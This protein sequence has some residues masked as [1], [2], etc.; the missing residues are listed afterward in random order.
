M[1]A[2]GSWGRQSSDTAG[3]RAGQQGRGGLGS[4]GTPTASSPLEPAR[5]CPLPAPALQLPARQLPASAGWWEEPS[6]SWVSPARP[7]RRGEL[8][9]GNSRLPKPCP[10]RESEASSQQ[11]RWRP[12]SGPLP[13]SAPGGGHCGLSCV[14]PTPNLYGDTLS[15]GP[16]TRLSLEPGPHSGHEGEQVAG[17]DDPL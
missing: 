10:Q 1:D 13:S 5:K 14:P 11:G 12:R 4:E 7:C 3:V 8:C 9:S 16:Q 2:G 15:P 17:V 6:C